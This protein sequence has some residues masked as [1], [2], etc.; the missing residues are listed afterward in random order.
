MQALNNLSIKFKVV[1]A[2]TV[3][4][5]ATVAMGTFSNQRLGVVNDAAV[6]MRDNW[7]PATRDLSLPVSRGV[8]PPAGPGERARTRPRESKAR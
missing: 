8:A 7:L 6:E 3:V 5:V 4:L 1:I 2:F